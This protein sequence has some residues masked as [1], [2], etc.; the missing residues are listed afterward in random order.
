MSV[1]ALAALVGD[2]DESYAQ[3]DWYH[4]H[5]DA[6]DSIVSHG[7]QS[8]GGSGALPASSCFFF[9]ADES[10]AGGDGGPLS[11]EG[12]FSGMGMFD[13]DEEQ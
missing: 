3:N 4:R 13:C 9:D 12:V 5:R 6:I 7:E 10:S 11:P 1:Q 2:N 8:S